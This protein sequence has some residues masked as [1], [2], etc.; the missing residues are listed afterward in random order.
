M[1][2]ILELIL[3]H[4]IHSD[5]SRLFVNSRHSTVKQSIVDIQLGE[6]SFRFQNQTR[7]LFQ[8]FHTDVRKGWWGQNWEQDFIKSSATY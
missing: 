7:S 6:T 3:I 1:F 4:L 8:M 5:Y 2:S